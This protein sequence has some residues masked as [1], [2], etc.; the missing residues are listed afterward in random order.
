MKTAATLFGGILSIAAFFVTAVLA[1]AQTAPAGA[2]W[3]TAWATSQQ[4][5]GTTEI[6]N[7]TVRLIAR[8]SQGWSGPRRAALARRRAC[9]RV[10][11]ADPVWWGIERDGPSWR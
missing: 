10:E 2:R 5:A 11:S 6:R 1:G 3:R 8:T 9:H 4:V 7:T